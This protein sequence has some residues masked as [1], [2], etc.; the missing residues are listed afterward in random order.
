MADG[1]SHYKNVCLIL[2]FTVLQFLA[3]IIIITYNY[4]THHNDHITS[5]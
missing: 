2:V 3:T 4:N 1:T 5:L